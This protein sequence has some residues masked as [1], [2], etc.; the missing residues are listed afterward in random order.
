MKQVSF[1]ILFLCS[2]LICTAQKNYVLAVGIADYKEINDLG[3]CEN[4]AA[5]FGTLMQ[6]LSADVTLLTGKDA[7]HEKIITALRTMLAKAKPEDSAIFFF[8]GHG[9][10]GG[11]C[12]WDMAT[13]SPSVTNSMNTANIKPQIINTVNRY[14]GGVSYAE[15]QVLFR[16]SRA[17]KK[18]VIAD[19]CFSGGLKKGY[20][21]N[22][23]VQS[24]KNGEVIFLLSSQ[25]NETSLEF[26]NE[27]NGLFTTYLIKGL[28]G[29]SDTN[30]DRTI[31]LKE[32]YDYLFLKVTEYA[33]SIPHSQH[34]V[35]WGRAS[36]N[37]PILKIN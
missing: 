20:R 15:L 4:D 25:P 27:R 9:Y 3:L 22:A 2:T 6:D 13:N 1:L 33:N 28:R 36:D 26:S 14:Y 30:S 5:D 34:P 24:A 10:E 16:N 11:F 21:L 18:M 37:T 31:T 17:G 32:L 29:E 12:C 8:S 19:A 35:L 7:T 23:S